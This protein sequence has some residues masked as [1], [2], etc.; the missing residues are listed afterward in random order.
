MLLDIQDAVQSKFPSASISQFGSYPVGLSIFTSDIDISVDNVLSVPSAP[1]PLLAPVE[2]RTGANGASNGGTGNSKSGKRPLAA[3]DAPQV[4]KR[5][6]FDETESGAQHGAEE[7][8]TW[9]LDGGAGRE[10]VSNVSEITQDPT[11]APAPKTPAPARGGPVRMDDCFDDDFSEESSSGSDSDGDGAKSDSEFLPSDYATDSEY[12][13]GEPDSA[14][15]TSASCDR[16]QPDSELAASVADLPALTPAKLPLDIDVP[17]WDGVSADASNAA[18]HDTSGVLDDSL[19][20]GLYLLED[21]PSR[22][23]RQAAEVSKKEKVEVL[24]KIFKAI[25]VSRAAVNMYVFTN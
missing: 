13:E 7:P 5:I 1:A 19:A 10:V 12:F 22:A 2:Q 23:Q 3:E 25:K 14:V 17:F 4:N 11:P 15:A 6:K 20:D 16:E 9:V 8:V 21:A 18:L 24:T